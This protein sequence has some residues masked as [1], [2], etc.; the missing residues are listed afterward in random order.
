MKINKTALLAALIL[1]P[2]VTFGIPIVLTKVLTKD[3]ATEEVAP[4]TSNVTR[5]VTTQQKLVDYVNIDARELK[6]YIDRDK[7]IY[8]LD[9]HIPEQEHISTT[10]AFIPFDSLDKNISELPKDK[11][12]EIVVYCRSGNMSETASQTLIDMGYTNVKNL[13]G[14]IKAWKVAGYEL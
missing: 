9:V 1:A 5:S 6:S 13:T 12:T 4:P 8:L 2:L 10:D 7:D 3:T 11:D 14:G